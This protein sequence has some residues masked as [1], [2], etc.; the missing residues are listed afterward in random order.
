MNKFKNNEEIK[1]MIDVEISIKYDHELSNNELNQIFNIYNE[2][3]YE[4]KVNNRGK[5]DLVKKWISTYKIFKWYLAKIDKRVVGIAA[6]VYD[7]KNV[8]KFDIR[9]DRGVNISNVAVLEKYR[10]LGIAKLLMNTI[11]EEYNNKIDLVVEI[12]RGDNEFYAI[13]VKFY[14]SLGYQEYEED[15]PV[16]ETHLYLKLKNKINNVM[17]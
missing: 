12:K 17:N 13:L 16:N 2:C 4:N 14:M 5:I 11:N 6:F 8:K 7:Y 9:E 15:N 3:F 1:E 10:R